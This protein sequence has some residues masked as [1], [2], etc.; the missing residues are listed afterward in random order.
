MYDLIEFLN[1]KDGITVIMISHD[2]SAAVRYADHILHVG[3]EVFFGTK[4]AYL[5]SAFAHAFLKGGEANG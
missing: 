3:G 4:D 1:K 5:K 2:I